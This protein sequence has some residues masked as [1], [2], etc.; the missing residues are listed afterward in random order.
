[1]IVKRLDELRETGAAD[2]VAGGSVDVVRYLLA[3]DGAGFSVSDVVAP[4]GSE[5]PCNTR[6]T[7]RPTW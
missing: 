7:S 1:M 3:A 2:K 5:A 6:T 4:A